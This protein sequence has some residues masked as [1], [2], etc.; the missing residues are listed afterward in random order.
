MDSRFRGN[1]VISA[2]HVTFRLVVIPAKAGNPSP[3]SRYFE[4]RNLSPEESALFADLARHLQEPDRPATD[5]LRLPARSTI[6]S[7]RFGRSEP[8]RRRAAPCVHGFPCSPGPAERGRGGRC[9]SMRPW[10]PASA[11]IDVEYSNILPCPGRSPVRAIT[12]TIDGNHH[13]QGGSRPCPST[14]PTTSATWPWSGTAAPA[15]RP[16][17]RRCSHTQASSV[18]PGASRTAPRCATSIP[19]RRSIGTRCTAR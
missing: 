1:D 7:L 10:I 11:G 16:W 18:R 3:D 13:R 9:G 6:H 17:S 19:R 4:S 12:T 14:P 5:G 8:Y 15:R 2:R